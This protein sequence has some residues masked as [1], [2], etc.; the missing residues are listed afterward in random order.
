MIEFI[1]IRHGATAW[2][3]EKRYQ[4]SSDICLSSQGK[5]QIHRLSRVISSYN[6]DLL[7]SSTLSRAKESADILFK[8]LK[9]RIIRDERINELSF[10]KWEGKTAD[11]LIKE[12]DISYQKWMQ[13]YLIKPPSGE[14][15]VSLKKRVYLFMQDCLKKHEGKT[16]A[17]VSHGGVLRSFIVEALNL[18]RKKLF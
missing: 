13:G 2:S 4:G 12:K 15:V 9:K 5:K 3:E 14:S 7:Y 6:P 1:L 17:I 11:E 8:P 16:V 10:G 18:S